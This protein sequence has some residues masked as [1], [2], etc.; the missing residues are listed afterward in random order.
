MSVFMLGLFVMP[1]PDQGFA[2]NG[3]K[4]L[5]PVPLPYRLVALGNVA[6]LAA[7]NKIAFNCQT[8][9]ACW[10]DVIESWR[11]VNAAVTICTLPVPC[12]QD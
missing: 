12:F 6:G 2:C 1:N 7:G 3:V 9:F 5:S 4:R 11:F 10:N 8:A